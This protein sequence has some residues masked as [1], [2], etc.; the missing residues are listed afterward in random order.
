MGRTGAPYAKQKLEP[1]A[2]DYD[3]LPYYMEPSE[4]P[5]RES[6]KEYPLV[7][8]N[9]RLPM[10]HHS[11]LRNIPYLREIYPVPEVWIN[12]E[13]AAKYGISQGDWTWIESKRG[14]TQGKA[15][16]TEGINPGVLYMERFWFPEK[17]SAPTH[18]WQE[19]NVNVLS[20]NTAPFNDMVGTYTLRGYQVRISKAD[21][22]PEGIWTK[23]EDFKG[24]MAQP[25]DN[26]PKIEG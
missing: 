19:A 20:K 23:P 7:M 11:T 9:G 18:G 14:K 26:T 6:A 24:W 22:G 8:T 12:P 2:K 17:L 16:L 10:Y 13:T 4:S 25:S 21:K 15:R 5:N 3:P 1:V